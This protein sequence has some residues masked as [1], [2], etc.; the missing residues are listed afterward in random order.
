MKK[1][2]GFKRGFTLVELLVVIAII[3][4]LISLLLPAVQSAREAA[5]RI[6]CINHLKQIGIAVHNFHD[7]RNGLPPSAIF[8]QKPTIFCLLYPYI[9][10]QGLYDVMHTIKAGPAKHEPPFVTNG[11]NL[12]NVGQW[13]GKNGANGA[14]R[15]DNYYL[16]AAF[17]GVS[18]YRCPTRPRPSGSQN[19]VDQDNWESLRGAGVNDNNLGPRGDYVVVLAWNPVNDSQQNIDSSWCNALS[20]TSKGTT[21]DV[22][23][24]PTFYQDRNSSPFR[25]ALCS[26][27]PTASPAGTWWWST[28]ADRQYITE[29]RTRDNISWWS[30]GTSNQLI[31]G[32]KFIPF[33]TL[34]LDGQWDGGYI[35]T[36]QSNQNANVGRAV[37]K[38]FPSIKRSDKDYDYNWTDINNS[39]LYVTGSG[40]GVNANHAQNVFGGIHPGVCNFL[41]GD[42]SVRPVP[43]TTNSAI[44]WGLGA[45]NDGEAVSLP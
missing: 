15:N 21:V 20:A 7:A 14:L 16:R 38:H 43:P 5:R 44:V 9:E 40:G 2:F 37:W 19:I 22:N 28:G 29:W 31:F 24:G 33:Q 6:Q 32:E 36:N 39:D 25:P 45:V 12:N 27:A 23:N 42:G 13:F 30:D 10:Q 35:G 1:Y 26:N 17:G 34:G 8:T 18:I 41:I 4:V 11:D 3:G